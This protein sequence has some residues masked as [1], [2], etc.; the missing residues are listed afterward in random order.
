MTPV[1]EFKADKIHRK[2]GWGKFCCE[3]QKKHPELKILKTDCERLKWS[4]GY[5]FGSCD[6]TNMTFE[7]FK[8]GS[9]AI[10]LHHFDDHSCCSDWCR[11][12]DAKIGKTA[13][14]M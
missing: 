1:E 2:R 10:L 4:M 9:W 13:S 5:Y 3:S 11:Y 7:E 6:G 14:I 8:W 12:K